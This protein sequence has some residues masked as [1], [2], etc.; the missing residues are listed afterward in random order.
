VSKR[1]YPESPYLGSDV[2]ELQAFGASLGLVKRL[3]TDGHDRNCATLQSLD[4]Q[5]CSC[6]L[7]RKRRKPGKVKS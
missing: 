4:N 2:A 3:E 5:P 6:A 7:E 1:A